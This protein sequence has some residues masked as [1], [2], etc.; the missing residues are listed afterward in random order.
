M[1]GRCNSVGFFKKTVLLAVLAGV[2]GSVIP[3]QAGNRTGPPPPPPPPPT[4]KPI[5]SL[6]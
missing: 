2:L 4:P 1:D 5:V 3:V 6:G